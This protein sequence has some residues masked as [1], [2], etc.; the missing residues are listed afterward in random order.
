MPEETP[1]RIAVL[2]I[3]L[4][5]GLF[6]SYHRVRAR[7]DEQITHDAE[8]RAFALV[9]RL[10]GLGLWLS[11]LAYLVAPRS[12]AWAA[13]PI[14]PAARWCAVVVAA[15]AAV[16]FMR[17]LVALGKNLTDT[18]VTRREARLVTDGPYAWVRHPFYTTAFILMAAVAVAAAN[19]LIGA[20]V[21]GV[22]TMLV[23]RTPREEERLIAAFGDEY[24]EYMRTTG[25]Y[26]PRVFGRRSS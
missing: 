14:S 12:I 9:L 13:V 23:V 16:G 17:T 4:G 26:W 18:V 1:F 15:A 3:M 22:V 6:A 2:V 11:T 21:A 5:T 7:T 20:C 10:F 8:G 25:R 19:L 24:R